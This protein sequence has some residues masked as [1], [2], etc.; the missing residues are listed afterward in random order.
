MRENY[1][2][3]SLKGKRILVTGASS[4]IGKSIAL[5]CSRM[6]ADLILV[7]RN[8]ERLIR[9]FTELEDGDHSYFSCD[10][11]DSQ[12]IEDLCNHVGV[13]DGLVHSAGMGLTLPFKFTTY[14]ILRKMMRLKFESPVLLTQ[15]LL[16]Y[17]R[18]N[19]G[20]SIVYL[21]SIDGPITGHIGNSIY[22]ASKS[23]IQ[24]IAKVQ[25]VELA[26]QR[27]RVNC[28]LPARVETPF[29]HRDNIS[30]EQVSKNQLSYPLK[31][32]AKPEEIAYYAIYLLS[33]ASTFTTGSSL[34][35]DGG[36]TLL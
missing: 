7:A 19:K 10:I 22:A 29:I 27:I 30:E 20:A 14:E 34:A 4:G 24:G 9:A 3:F 36:Y 25:A 26:A 21:S 18:I 6:G 12:S 31:R 35:I 33:N 1:N 5:E 16:K 8:E 13:I 32:Y 28:I 11:A 17:K 2:P 15:K 23:A